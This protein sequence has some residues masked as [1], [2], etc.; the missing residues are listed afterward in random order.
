MDSFMDEWLWGPAGAAF[1]VTYPAKTT[2]FAGR[3]IRRCAQLCGNRF[4]LPIR[5]KPRF[6]PDAKSGAAL[7]S[8]E[9]ACDF[10][11]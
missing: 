7:N 1:S 5:Q 8:A 11:Q 4:P 10:R 2:F 3:Q 6:L 9:I